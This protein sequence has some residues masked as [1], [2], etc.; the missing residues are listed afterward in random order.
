M[1]SQQEYDIHVSLAMPKS[2]ANLERGNFMISLHL[3]ES[4]V[5]MGL[6]SSARQ[7]ASHHEDFGNHKV[8]F[9]SRRPVLLQY[10]DPMVSYVS[11]ILFLFYH[12]L[13][14]GSSTVTVRIP[15]AER[16][17][18]SKGSVVPNS[19]YIEVE[20]G[21]TV[22][23]YH[24]TLSLTAQLRGLRWLMFYYRLPTF[25]AFT[26]F[27]WVSEVVSMAVAWIVWSAVFGSSDT[28]GKGKYLEGSGRHG[29]GDESEEKEEDSDRP[30]TFPTY[31]RQPPL[32]YEPELKYEGEEER[33]LSEVPIA[34]AEADDEEDEDE[35]DR[36]YRDSGIGTSY[37]EEGKSSIRKRSSR[38]TMD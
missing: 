9:S 26:F 36:Q 25:L 20:A 15:L 30:T 1:L 12:M 13:F 29:L 17:L 16:V 23:T 3:L 37:S 32:K 14:P 24:A 28:A 27:F 34:G 4:K 6:E 22:Q 7:Y 5:D 18:F 38:N 19:A 21:Q 31:G 10:V 35:Y 11:R 33:P 2:P 8:L